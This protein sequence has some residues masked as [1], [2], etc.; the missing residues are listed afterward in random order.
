MSEQKPSAPPDPDGEEQA[1]TDPAH[2]VALVVMVATPLLLGAAVWA[3]LK[4]LSGA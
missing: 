1:P 3:L 4:V 2:R